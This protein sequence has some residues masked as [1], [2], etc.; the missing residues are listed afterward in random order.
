VLF[1]SLN[2]HEAGLFAESQYV[3]IYVFRVTRPFASVRI[4]I[5]EALQKGKI[6]VYES[7]VIYKNWNQCDCRFSDWRP[8]SVRIWCF[9][10]RLYL[11]LA[12]SNPFN[13]SCLLRRCSSMEIS[14]SSLPPTTCPPP[15]PH[16][17]P[18]SSPPSSP[19]RVALNSIFL[20]AA[21]FYFVCKSQKKQNVRRFHVLQK[22]PMF[23]Q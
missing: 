13:F 7:W 1:W 10:L 15:Q 18:S 6:R 21:A 22:S 2:I 14:S 12:F 16:S 19:V 4:W 11:T 9:G 8:S 20:A 23:L 5:E 3:T 17:A